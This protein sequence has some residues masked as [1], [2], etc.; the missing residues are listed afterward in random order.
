MPLQPAPLQPTKVDPIA[1]VAVSV[2]EVPWPK[3]AVQVLPQEMPAGLEVMV[4]EPVPPLVTV[5][6]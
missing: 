1:A 2:T 4:A 6:G 5:S 3:L